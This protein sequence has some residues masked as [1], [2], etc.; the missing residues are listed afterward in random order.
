M[1]AG[2]Q[3]FG[4]DGRKPNSGWEK[5]ARGLR[6]ASGCR[7]IVEMM[8]RGGGIRKA[9][10]SPRER[11]SNDNNNNINNN[12]KEIKGRQQDEKKKIFDGLCFYVN[13]ST[14]PEVSD[15]RL[16]Y[17]IAENG[18]R[19]SIGLGRRTVTHV[20]LGNEGTGGGLAAG[21]LQKEIRRLGGCVV[22]YVRVEW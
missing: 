13:G 2:S 17:L 18:G 19:V 20:V 4:F 22:K 9:G 1:G 21:K 15:H 6:Q 12:T 5:G 11:K 8:T 16:K 7:S 14:A 3:S 10:L